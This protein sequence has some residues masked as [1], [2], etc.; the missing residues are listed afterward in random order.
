MGTRAVYFFEERPENGYGRDEDCYYG[1]Y[2]H[3]DGY[4]Q[5]AACLLYTSPSPRDLS[6]SRMPSSA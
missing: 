2:K 3:Y 6:T 5:G 1:V 4:P